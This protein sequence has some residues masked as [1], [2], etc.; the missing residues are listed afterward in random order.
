[1]NSESRIA[2]ILQAIE[3]HSADREL[4]ALTVA[5]RLGITPR[6]VHLLLEQTGKSFTHHLLER[7]L[8]RALTL[9]RDPQWHSR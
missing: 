7:R 4:T 6:Y 3:R 2:D 9:L 5:N 1:M 8:E